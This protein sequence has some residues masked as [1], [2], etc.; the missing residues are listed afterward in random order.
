MGQAGSYKIA[1]VQR[2]NLGLVLQSPK[3]ST[4]DDTVIILFKFTS[5]VRGLFC[6]IKTAPHTFCR[7]QRIPLHD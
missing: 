4:A 6:R 5:Q 3:G 1:F 7:K 2:K